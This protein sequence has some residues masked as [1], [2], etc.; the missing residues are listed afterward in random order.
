MLAVPP[1]TMS[2]SAV[3]PLRV[4]PIRF[5]ALF[6][7]FSVT[8]TMGSAVVTAASAPAYSRPWGQMPRRQCR[9]SSPSPSNP[10]R[11]SCR[12]WSSSCRQ[13]A[14]PHHRKR[15]VLEQRTVQGASIP[16]VA[17]PCRRKSIHTG[18]G[19]G[20]GHRADE[21]RPTVV[22]GLPGLLPIEAS[23]GKWS[24]TSKAAGCTEVGNFKMIEAPRSGDF[25][26]LSAGCL[27]LFRRPDGH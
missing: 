13:R 20:A 3:K 19:A 2:T 1:A 15:A 16:G 27:T 24:S 8:Y 11:R 9:H 14:R 25:E 7:A 17:W 12:R 5:I 22:Q 21:R 18:H 6:R 10:M 26:G 23:D 4:C